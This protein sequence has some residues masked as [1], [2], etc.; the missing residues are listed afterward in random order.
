MVENLYNFSFRRSYGDS[1]YEIK[2][3]KLFERKRKFEIKQ[4]EN[5]R[6]S[7]KL[8]KNVEMHLVRLKFFYIFA[9]PKNN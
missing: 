9:A 6:T 8:R 3:G 7:E 4:H 2:L 5:Q 1:K